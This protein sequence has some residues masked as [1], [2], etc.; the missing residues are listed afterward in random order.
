[1]HVM[2]FVMRDLFHVCISLPLSSRIYHAAIQKV[3]ITVKTDATTGLNHPMK[4]SASVINKYTKEAKRRKRPEKG[5]FVFVG[6]FM[7]NGKSDDFT[8]PLGRGGPSGGWGF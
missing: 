6:E 5:V 8:P 1:M 3:I 7:R 4:K 2:N